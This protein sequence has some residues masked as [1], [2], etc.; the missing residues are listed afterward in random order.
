VA[1]QHNINAWGRDLD[2]D[3]W[4][5]D[6]NTI[7]FSWQT[8]EGAGDE[9]ELI[10]LLDGQTRL[11]TIA[12]G[13][14]GEWSAVVVGLDPKARWVMDSGAPRKVA[15]YLQMMKVPYA[16]QVEGLT[17]RWLLWQEGKRV[18]LPKEKPSHA[19]QLE[20]YFQNA[21]LLG[22]AARYAVSTRDKSKRELPYL[23]LNVWGLAWLAF[24]DKAGQETAEYFLHKVASGLQLEDEGDP[25]AALRTRIRNAQ[26]DREKVSELEKL[27]F[28]IDAFSKFRAGEKVSRLQLPKGRKLV[29]SDLQVY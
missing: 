20:F 14:K 13:T 23:G 27:F 28:V 12:Q 8:A 29:A 3:D 17:K 2:A 24:C 7:R 10:E 26:A 19:A 16:V 21:S 22:D 4:M 6:G 11:M 5:I 15:H 25:A 18:E 9:L 1:N